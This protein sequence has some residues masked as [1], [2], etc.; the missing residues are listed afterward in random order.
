MFVTK[1][2]LSLIVIA[3]A[4]GFS[5]LA[6]LFSRFLGFCRRQKKHENEAFGYECGF[7]ASL[8]DNLIYI[9]EKT[10]FVSIYLVF[11]L[12]ISWLLLC[13]AFYIMNKD[14]SWQLF[15]KVFLL[16]IFAI[17][18]VSYRLLFYHSQK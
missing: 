18:L 6:L 14:L 13:C 9:T 12:A 3:V 1:V 8:D 11:E 4:G 16:A 2:S 5:V 17:M 10:S 15:I 7:N